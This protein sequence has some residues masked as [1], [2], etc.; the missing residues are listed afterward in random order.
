MTKTH[1]LLSTAAVVAALGAS[2]LPAMALPAADANAC[3]V[4]TAPARAITSYD[5]DWPSA[6]PPLSAVHGTALIRI[7]LAVDGTPN[8]PLVV[9]STGFTTLDRAAEV[10]TMSQ[11][12]APEIRN[13]AAVA[14]T[15]LYE[16]DY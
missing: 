11:H 3:T 1:T 12:F 10:A 8:S 16:V 13:C 6:L 14:G 7:Q 9:Q 2:M 5:A 4:R 15:Y